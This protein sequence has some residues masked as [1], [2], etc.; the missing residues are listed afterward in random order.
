MSSFDCIV[1]GSGN[2]GCCAALSSAEAGCDK[3]LIVDVCPDVWAGGNGYFTAGAFRTVHEGLHDLLPIVNNASKEKADSIDM[4]GY[5][6]E[7]F[8]G[9]IMRLGNGKPDPVLAAAVVDASRDTISWLAHSVGLPFM[10]SFHRQA[11]SVG[12]RQK[13]WGGLVLCTEDGGKGLIAAHQRALAKAKVAVWFNCPAVQITMENGTVSGVVV[14]KEGQKLHLRAPAVVLAAGGFE[15]NPVLRAQQLGLGWE[16]AILRGTPYNQGDGFALAAAVGARQAGDWA[17]CHSTCWDADAPTDAGRRDLTNQFT[18]SGY[19]LGI[20]VNS[21]GKRFVDEGEDFRNYTYAKFGK[22]ILLQPGGYAFQVWDSKVI[23]SLRKEEYGNGI[24]KKFLADRLED[25]A[26]QLTEVGL[27]GKA[28]FVQT[29]KQFNEATRKFQAENPDATWNPAV[30]DGMSTQSSEY[31]LPLPK[32]N[33]A[34][35]IDE[36]PFMA[37]KVACGVTF[38]FGGLA[39]DPDTAGVISEKT[40]KVIPGLFC[41]GEMVGLFHENYPGG[42]GL[43]AGAVFGR[44]AGQAA[45]KLRA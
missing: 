33:W 10:F 43:M 40:S 3:V 32:S 17:G 9:D 20:M 1:I 36:P 12:G 39:V 27:E 37:V 41:T 26:E 18:K 35:T 31:Q 28:E 21:A 42:S 23:G 19:P 38:T 7:D 44:K 13:F 16:R 14:E 6:G 15:S 30:K 2:A 22:A 8:L 5:S 34:L 29:T 4:D 45:A 11:Y 24:V 25:L